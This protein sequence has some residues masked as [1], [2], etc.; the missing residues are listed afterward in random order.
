MFLNEIF[1]N[2]EKCIIY[3]LISLSYVFKWNILMSCR[4]AGVQWCYIYYRFF[5]FVWSSKLYGRRYHNCTSMLDVSYSAEILFIGHFSM[6]LLGCCPYLQLCL[7]HCCE[8]ELVNS[9]YMVLLFSEL[10]TMGRSLLEG[11][12]ILVILFSLFRWVSF[13]LL[14]KLK[15]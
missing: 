6:L 15:T 4:N 13:V 5:Y 10:L 14:L 7:N 1:I 2:M 9:T 11:I 12:G 3:S 8:M